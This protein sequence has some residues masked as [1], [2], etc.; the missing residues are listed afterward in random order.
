MQKDGDG[1]GDP[2]APSVLNKLQKWADYEAMGSPVWPTRFLPMKTPMSNEILGSWSLAEA[3]KHPLTVPRLLETQSKLGRT[4]GLI[5]DLANHDCLYSD[6]MPESLEYEHVQLIAKVLPTREAIAEVERIANSFW[7]QHPEQHIAIHCAYGFNRTGFV[8]CSYLCQACGLSVEQA[9][10]SFAAARPP[11]VKHEKFIRELHVRYGSTTAS[12]ATTPESG[13]LLGASPPAADTLA[14][15]AVWLRQHGSAAIA[16]AAAAAAD[17][18]GGQAPGPNVPA[19]AAAA[20]ALL[21]DEAAVSD[22]QR[23]VQQQ[24]QREEEDQHFEDAAAMVRQA[25]QRSRTLSLRGS[26]GVETLKPAGKASPCGGGSS[27]GSF[28][29]D[30][31]GHSGLAEAAV[32]MEL[33]AAASSEAVEDAD[34]WVA[35][36]A[37]VGFDASRKLRM[38]N[39]SRGAAANC[40]N[41]G[42]NGGGLSQALAGSS[43]A[44]H[45]DSPDSSASFAVGAEAS[46]ANGLRTGTSS[47]SD[48]AA[49]AAHLEGHSSMRRSTSLV[50]ARALTDDFLQNNG[51]PSNAELAPS[52]VAE[53]WSKGLLRA[54]GDSSAEQPDGEQPATAQPDEQ[55][56]Q[57]RS[58]QQP[59]CGPQTS[60]SNGSTLPGELDVAAAIPCSRLCGAA[61]TCRGCRGGGRERDRGE[62]EGDE[63]QEAEAEVEVEEEEEGE[64]QLPAE[65]R[66]GS[67][68]RRGGIPLPLPVPAPAVLRPPGTVT[69]TFQQHL[70]QQLAQQQQPAT[71]ATPG[72]STVT[73]PPC[74]TGPRHSA[75][76]RRSASVDS[77]N[78]SLGFG[79]REVLLQLR[80]GAASGRTNVRGPEA[81]ANLFRDA[82]AD[83]LDLDGLSVE[84][85]LAAMELS[86]GLDSPA[87][88]GLLPRVLEAPADYSASSWGQHS[89]RPS[90]AAAQPPP[91]QL[92]PQGDA[93][94]AAAAAIGLGR[95]YQQQH[96][97]QQQQQ[98][99]RQQEEAPSKRGRGGHRGP[100]AIM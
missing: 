85:H 40:G 55:Q 35:T 37:G 3:P 77:D 78:P 47:M 53:A 5:I 70:Q 25:S 93:G 34:A 66:G 54:A 10:E 29:H 79:V 26:G 19:P 4:V 24:Q 30:H 44:L 87:V 18:G 60:P 1:E 81:L 43:S 23:Q 42:G 67:P 89:S 6:D 28:N 88:S 39:P 8:V 22:Q 15:E 14:A 76:F 16:A 41:G 100:C 33:D 51:T 84:D 12:M 2:P 80:G 63:E 27:G 72:S 69:T 61:C 7:A 48:F 31:S 71:P 50:L 68:T 32:A 73:P 38:R 62:H 97:Q 82:S 9:L 59:P 49:A 21:A 11:G 52:A 75:S 92:E 91:L 96:S 86:A 36:T 99:Q 64:E 98:Q 58:Q 20:A 46:L 57:Q 56:S 65:R 13:S 95:S 83:Q 45:G 94:G 17:G 90:S 74:G